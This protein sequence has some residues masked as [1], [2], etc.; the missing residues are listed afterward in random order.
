M[1]LN[2]VTPENFFKKCTYSADPSPEGKIVMSN[3][4]FIQTAVHLKLIEEIKKLKDAL[5][6]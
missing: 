3:G 1:D 5:N 6:K 4:V 2:D